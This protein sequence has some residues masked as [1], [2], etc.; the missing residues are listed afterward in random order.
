MYKIIIDTKHQKYIFIIKITPLKILY[1]VKYTF[2]FSYVKNEIV[3]N[4][5]VNY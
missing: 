3:K 5:I 2:L 1:L 4:E